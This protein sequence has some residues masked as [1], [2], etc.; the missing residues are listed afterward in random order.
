MK[1]SPQIEDGYTRIANE[2]YEAILGFGFTQRQLLV[3]LTVLRK[4]YGYGKK[5]DDMS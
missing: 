4:T 2:L 1:P 3:L 5:E